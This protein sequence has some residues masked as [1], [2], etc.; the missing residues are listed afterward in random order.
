MSSLENISSEAVT[1]LAFVDSYT[2]KSDPS[3]LIPTLWLGTSLGSVLTVSI[4]LPEPETRNTSPVLVSILGGP[5]FR[6]KGSILC[7]SFLDCNGALIPY[8]YEP[9]KD[10]G[11]QRDKTPTKSSTN[12]MSPTLNQDTSFGDRQFMVITSEK[13]CR[14]VALPSQNCVYRLQITETDFVVRAEIVSMK[15]SVCLVCYVSNGHL[16]AFSLPSLRLLLDVD[17]LPLADLR[18][19]KT[20]CFSNRGHGLYLATPTEIQKFTLC[21]EFSQNYNDMLGDLYLQCEMPEPPKESFFKGLFGGG[22]KSIDRE[23]LFGECASGKPNRSVAKLI[24][25]PNANLQDLNSRANS[26]SNEFSRAH[27]MMIER[28]DK[29]NKLEDN[30]ERMAN[31]AQQFSGAAHQLMAKYRDKKWYQL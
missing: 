29:L 4:T 16:M 14:I 6:L 7:M 5:I 18:I 13:Q 1:C 26:A 23:E 10:E 17:F 25:G 24:S 30:A 11:K 27:Q 12:R 9:W 28:G 31:E 19:S 2:K 22:A 20:F 15:E 8:S 21:S 3:A